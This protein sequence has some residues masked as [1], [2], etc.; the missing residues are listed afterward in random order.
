MDKIITYFNNKYST[1]YDEIP[2]PVIKYVCKRYFVA[3][4]NPFNQLVFNI[5]NTYFQPPKY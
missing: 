3:A 1:G 4:F 2:M 5:W